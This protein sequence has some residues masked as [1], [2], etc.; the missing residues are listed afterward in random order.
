[1]TKELVIDSILEL[2]ENMSACNN[3]GVDVNA[4]FKLSKVL[5]ALGLHV[6]DLFFWV[7]SVRGITIFE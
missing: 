7:S 4:F 5:A 3:I 1:M 2:F 6:N